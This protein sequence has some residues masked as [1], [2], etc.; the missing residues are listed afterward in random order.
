MEKLLSPDIGLSIWTAVTFLLLV[1]LLG[2][3][4]WRPLVQALEER[5][6]A[7]RTEREAAE[8]ARKSAEEIKAQLDRELAQIQHKTQE[9]LAQAQ[10]E[11]A[12]QRD[13]VIRAAQEEALRMAE[14]TRI[15]LEEE[16]NRLVREL[17]NEVAGLSVLAAEKLLKKSMDPA[18]QKN[19]LEDFFKDMGKSKLR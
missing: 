1:L 14:K 7:M 18:V 9:L 3:A 6:R 8:A 13:Q 2:R 17:R 11:G 15:Q 10:R 19:A 4:A 5:E 16:K 12:T